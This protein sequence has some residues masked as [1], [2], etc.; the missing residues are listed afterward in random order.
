MNHSVLVPSGFG[1]GVVLMLV[2]AASV[3]VVQ[4]YQ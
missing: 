4:Q 3:R 2:A 1:L